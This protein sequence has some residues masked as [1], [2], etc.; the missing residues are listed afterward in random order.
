M[1]GQIPYIC[2]CIADVK[3]QIRMQIQGEHAYSY[4]AFYIHNISRIVIPSVAKFNRLHVVIFQ[5]KN[6]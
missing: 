1:S 4:N 6:I 5:F 3:V 2:I